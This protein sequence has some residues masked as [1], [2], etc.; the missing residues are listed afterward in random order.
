MIPREEA[1]G[2]LTEAAHAE[3]TGANN[4]M[5]LFTPEYTRHI[6]KLLTERAI[7][8]KVI[9]D[10][11][12]PY[13]ERMNVYRG[14][15]LPDKLQSV[16][17]DLEDKAAQAVSGV[18]QFNEDMSVYLRA[19]IIVLDT[20]GSAPTHREKEARL[21][22]AIEIIEGLLERLRQERCEFFHDFRWQDYFRSDYPTRVYINRIRELERK[23]KE[24]EAQDA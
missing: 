15:D 6:V 14:Y 12:R 9:E 8:K 19:M 13:E 17:R 3:M 11:L 7:D 22:G 10:L 4:S 20:A 1:D 23:V 16:L 2:L 24:L 18:K 5:V 21:R